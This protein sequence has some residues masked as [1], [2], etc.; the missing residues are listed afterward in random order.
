M[1]KLL[2]VVRREYLN[3]VRTKAFVIL[4]LLMPLLVVGSGALPALLLS[5]KTGEATRLAVVDETGRLYEAVRGS[6]L[7]ARDE[8]DEGAR[9]ARPALPSRSVPGAGDEEQMRQMGE[10]MGLSFLIERVDPSGRSPE[11]VRR[12]LDERVRRKELDA[13]LILPADVLAPAGRA[14]YHARNVSDLITTS[15][16]RHGLRRAV[17]EERMRGANIDPGR[18]SEL[19]REVGL[20][21]FKA[22]G[23]GKDTGGGFGLAMGTG[24]FVYMAILLYGQAILQS[25]VEDKTTRI[26]EVLF[27]SVNPFQLLAGKLVGVSLVGLT[28]IAAWSLFFLGVTAYGAAMLAAGGVSFSL[29][30]VEPA[31]FVCA[32]LFFLAGFFLYGTLYVFIGA[33]VSSEKEAGQMALPVVFLSVLSVYLAFPVIRSPGSPFA[34]WVSMTPFFSPVA[35]LVRVV[36]ERPP[37]WQI[38]LSLAV[39]AA[40]TVLLVW[41]AARVYRVGMLMYGKSASIP[42]ALRWLRRA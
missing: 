3:R 34:F 6:L 20:D 4:T 32:F 38:A 15:Q 5:V 35:M 33:V 31:F 27:S 30:T 42:E 22:G 16:I 24:L 14:E 11:E 37:V 40:T 17:I 26:S 28:Q 18:V 29:P 2:V 39:S 7:R 23:G 9:A 10:A 19:S 21:A 1:R 41:V 8:N 12:A 13:Y 36:T 25:V